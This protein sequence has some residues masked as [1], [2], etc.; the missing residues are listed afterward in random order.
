MLDMNQQKLNTTFHTHLITISKTAAGFSASEV[1]G[2]SPEQ[3]RRAA[4]ALV[5]AGTIVRFKVTPRRVRYFANEKLAQAYVSGQAPAVRRLAAIG[6]RS[7][8]QWRPED[9]GVITSRTK[10][11]IAPPLPKRTYR[12]N[13]YTQF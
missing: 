8:A 12:T 10:I 4:E 7:K 1:T 6:P 2:Y 3:V 11:T 13:T 5:G 9:P